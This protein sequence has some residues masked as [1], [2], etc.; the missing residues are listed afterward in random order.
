LAPGK[1]KVSELFFEVPVDHAN[2]SS[3]TIQVFAR[4]VLRYENP[5]IPL[6]IE[7]ASTKAQKP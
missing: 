4:G 1:L 7:A 6:S 2:P 3:A 5:I